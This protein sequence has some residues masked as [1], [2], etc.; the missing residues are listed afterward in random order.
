MAFA[1]PQR[2]SFPLCTIGIVKRNKSRL[3]AHGE[4]H[5]ARAQIGIHLMAELFDFA[6]LIIRVGL[7]DARGFVNSLDRHL[8]PEI[9]IGR[10]EDAADGAGGTAGVGSAGERNV[11]FA[12]KQSGGRIES[13]PSG[14]RQIDFSPSVQIGEI[15]GG[16]GRPF[17]RPH[18][19]D[20]LNQVAGD[21]SRREPPDG[22]SP[23]PAA[24]PN[25]GTN[26]CAA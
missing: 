7:G 13:N 11:A 6:P 5:I 18:V 12:G 19:G 3:A 25:R 26:R 24:M 22:A 8:M 20:E 4:A 21:E 10:A 9:R 17:E 15:G 16:A 1:G 2:G 14:T 23:G